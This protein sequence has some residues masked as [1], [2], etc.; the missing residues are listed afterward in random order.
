[1]EKKFLTDNSAF[2]HAVKDVIKKH[3]ISTAA[4]MSSCHISHSA[5]WHIKK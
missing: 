4:V 1:M 2:A 3:H 5:F